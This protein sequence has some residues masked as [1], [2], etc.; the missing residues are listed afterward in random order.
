MRPSSLLPIA[1]PLRRMLSGTLDWTTSHPTDGTGRTTG[2]GVA[3]VDA[4][5]T[6]GAAT[7]PAGLMAG[8]LAARGSLGWDAAC[9][10]PFAPGFGPG[11]EG[12]GV[13]G[14]SVPAVRISTY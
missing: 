3:A 14:E 13:D 10:P 2:A 9:D 12:V 11:A 1:S 4:A 8:G 7:L 5:A 6:V